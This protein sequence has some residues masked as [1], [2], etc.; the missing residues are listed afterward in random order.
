LCSKPI[1][2]KEAKQ[3]ADLRDYLAAERTFFAWVRTGLA[4]MGAKATPHIRKP[5]KLIP[6]HG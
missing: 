3:R 1:A 6:T 2:S 5:T 4:L